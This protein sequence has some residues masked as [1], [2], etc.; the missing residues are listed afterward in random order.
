MI[1]S[2]LILLRKL[3][4]A[5]R[6]E[7]TRHAASCE[8]VSVDFGL[9]RLRYTG[10]GTNISAALWLV[11]RQLLFELSFKRGLKKQLSQ[12][13]I[14]QLIQMSNAPFRFYIALTWLSLKRI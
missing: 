7:Y 8:S 10:S 14:L 13:P 12:C 2:R 9:L 1:A 5:Q 3:L 4:I 11:S 6:S